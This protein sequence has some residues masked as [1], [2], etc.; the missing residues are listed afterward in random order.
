MQVGDLVR[1]IDVGMPTSLGLGVVIESI[2]TSHPD[3]KD[4]TVLWSEGHISDFYADYSTLEVVNSLSIK[5]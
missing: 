2:S 1:T 4:L 5:K 3:I